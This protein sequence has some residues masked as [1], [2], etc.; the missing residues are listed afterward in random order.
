MEL[1][2]FLKNEMKKRED[3]FSEI[4]NIRLFVGSWNLGGQKAPIET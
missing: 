1:R 4:K 3:L 2:S